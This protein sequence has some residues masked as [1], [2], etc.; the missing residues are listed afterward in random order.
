MEIVLLLVF[1]FASKVEV[2]FKNLNGNYNTDTPSIR[3]ISW[4]QSKMALRICSF[5]LM[6]IGMI[7][8][9]TSLN[10]AQSVSL[11]SSGLHL[12]YPFN[13]KHPLTIT[14]NQI[15]EIR[16]GETAN[17]GC[18]NQDEPR[19]LVEKTV[20][21]FLNDNSVLNEEMNDLGPDVLNQIKTI[22]SE[23]GVKCQKQETADE[24]NW[25]KN[26]VFCFFTPISVFYFNSNMCH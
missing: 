11:D 22:I 17:R 18:A 13:L 15:S 3:Q 16:I 20:R 8:I 4:F 25:D 24:S 23:S 1:I 12:V 5:F 26:S 10:N 2:L 9:L 21:I 6:V 7:F 19:N 14:F